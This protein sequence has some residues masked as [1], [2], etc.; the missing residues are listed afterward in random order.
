MAI[1]VGEA[2]LEPARGFPHSILSARCL[3]VS[4]L[5]D[6]WWEREDSN[7]QQADYLK[8]FAVFAIVK[9]IIISVALPVEL[10]SHK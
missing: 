4:P 9:T 6:E 10:L 3:P 5:A 2:G 7:L 1:L 8:R